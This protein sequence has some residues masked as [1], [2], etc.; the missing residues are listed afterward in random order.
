[1]PVFFA[2]H[3]SLILIRSQSA[4]SL[5]TVR[6]R[7]GDRFCWGGKKSNV[8]VFVDSDFFKTLQIRFMTDN[9]LHNMK[10]YA[11]N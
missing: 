9:D 8:Y 1:M 5:V 4:S 6:T 7:M 2:T 3:D 10:I 11:I